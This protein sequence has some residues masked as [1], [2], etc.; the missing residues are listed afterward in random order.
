MLGAVPPFSLLSTVT[1][2]GSF[3]GIDLDEKNPSPT[4][5]SLL[6]VHAVTPACDVKAF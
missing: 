5:P 2:R 4:P 6:V 3:S 1:I